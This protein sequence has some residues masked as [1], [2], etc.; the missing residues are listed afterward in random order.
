[1]VSILVMNGQ[2][3]FRKTIRDLAEVSTVHGLRYALNFQSHFLDRFLWTVTVV[4]AMGLGIYT[5]AR[6][7]LDW[8]NDPVTT[9]IGTVALPITD[10]DFPAITL[11][12]PGNDMKGLYKVADILRED[13]D[14]FWNASERRT[15]RGE[16]R[17][18]R[19]MDPE[20][21]KEVVREFMAD[22]IPGWPENLTL[23]RFLLHMTTD[24]EALAV[25]FLF[26]T[27][28]YA[29][30]GVPDF[31][32]LFNPDR[33]EEKAQ[34]LRDVQEDISTHFSSLDFSSE[35]AHRALLT[36]LW[37]TGLPCSELMAQC[38]W[39]G[40]VVPCSAIF[41]LIPTDIGFCCSFNH[42]P[43]VVMLRN[44]SFARILT[45]IEER[46]KAAPDAEGNVE[47][48]CDEECQKQIKAI[49]PQAGKHNG[50]QVSKKR[51]AC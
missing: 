46:Y 19:E 48:G 44:S 27:E 34:A 8:Q 9:T 26:K 3:P 47:A 14:A 36:A 30:P 21:V 29:R 11:C 4:I 35:R 25:L 40:V 18:L 43:L 51:I 50:L 16:G 49:T 17:T 32:I 2:S 6:L 20:T 7:Y 13:W 22:S 1:M 33:A 12:S 23:E 28:K 31:D 24:H 42:D 41:H 15:R 45:E 38:K 10:I 39:K 37:F 5:S